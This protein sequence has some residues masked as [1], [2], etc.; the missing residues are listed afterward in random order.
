MPVFY[1]AVGFDDYDWTDHLSPQLT[2]IAQPLEKLEAR[3]VQ[4]RDRIMKPDERWRIVRLVP[5]LRPPK[6]L[7]VLRYS[8][9]CANE[10]VVLLEVRQEAR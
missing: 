1:H 7:W 9:S 6:L 10:I 5:E 2:V 8:D 4:L 3:S